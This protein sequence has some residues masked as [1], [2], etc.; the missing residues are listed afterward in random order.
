M[1]DLSLSP[2]RTLLR[3]VALPT[4][5][6]GWGFL[7]EPI[8][9]GLWVAGSLPGVLLT[10]AA[11]GIFLLH[12]PLKL[13]LKDFGQRRRTARSTWAVRFALMYGA[14]ALIPF[15]VLLFSMPW[16]FLLPLALAVPFAGVQLAYEVRTQGRRFLP[17]VCGALALALTAPACVLLAGEAWTIALSLWVLLGL[18]AVT[19]IAYVRARLR[20][21]YGKPISPASVWAGH[22][23]AVL[24][25]VVMAALQR[26]P[27]L[28]VAAFGLLLARAALGL[29]RHRQ[30]QPAK[31]IGFQEIAYGLMFVAFV[32]VGYHWNL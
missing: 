1:A 18:R 22:V 16:D 26:A 29:S 17:E 5:H 3:S 8:V 15:G 28:G 10:V 11:L 20:L 21:E 6:G 12:Q 30:P 25:A 2:S 23:L 31:V 9:L 7:F 19:A 32:A 13:A 4:E 14:L 27:W 24:A